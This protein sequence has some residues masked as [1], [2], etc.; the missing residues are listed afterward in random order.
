MRF[1]TDPRSS[2]L[3]ANH[4]EQSGRQASYHP[5]YSQYYQRMLLEDAYDQQANYNAELELRTA[6]WQT[7]ATNRP[8]HWQMRQEGAA[9]YIALKR[10]EA[11]AFADAAWG[12]PLLAVAY[13]TASAM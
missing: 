10:A 9:K 13:Q 12:E 5:E 4:S 8:P 1:K 6:E 7:Y 3:I 11:V 2:G